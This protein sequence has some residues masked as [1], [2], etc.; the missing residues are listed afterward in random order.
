MFCEPDP[1]RWWGEFCRAIGAP[2]LTD[3]P[4]YADAGARSANRQELYATL[5]EKFAQKTLAQWLKILQD[6][7]LSMAY[8]P[9]NS[10]AELAQDPQA[11]ANRYITEIEHPKR[12][13]MKVAGIPLQF[14]GTPTSTMSAAPELGQHTDEVLSQVGGLS[15]EEIARLRSQGVMG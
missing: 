14:S 5:D 4:R 2:D 12:G 15:S 7:G 9:V 3:D 10:P 8:S 1:D 11:T 13:K 6:A